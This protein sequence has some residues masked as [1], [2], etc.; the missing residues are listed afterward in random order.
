MQ[1]IFMV[2]LGGGAISLPPNYQSHVKS[3]AETGQR[4]FQILDILLCFETTTLC[5]KAKFH[6][7]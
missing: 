1:G 2:R 4:V 3:G 7:F 5:L 6:A